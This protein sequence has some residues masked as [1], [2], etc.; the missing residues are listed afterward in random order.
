MTI[1]K[2]M[3]EVRV[4]IKVNPKHNDKVQT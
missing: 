1:R 4:G 3:K 2:D